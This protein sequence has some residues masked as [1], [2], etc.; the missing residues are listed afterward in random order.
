MREFAEIV[1][2]RR[3]GVHFD[4]YT[5]DAFWFAPGGAYRDWRR[6]TWPT[7][8][9][10]WLAE[11]RRHGI[12][13]GLWFST[14]TL[15][16]LDAAPAWKESLNSKQSAM[17]F[18]E[19]GFLPDFMATLQ[20]WY[21]RGIRLFKFDFADFSA[22]TPQAEKSQRPESIRSRNETAFRD[23]L[24]SFRRENPDVVLVAFNGFG[25][26]F[27][28]TAGPSPFH[29]R[30]DTRWLEV[31]DGLYSGDPRPSDVPQMNFWRSVDIYSDHM[32]RRFEQSGVP[33]ERIDSTAFMI[34]NT[35][36]NYYRKTAA[37][38][39]M[40]LLLVARGG[41]INTIYGNLEFID[42]ARAPWFAKVQSIYAPLQAVGRTESFGGLP[43]DAEPY[44]FASW[45]PG[46]IIYT[47]V[48]P[49]QR[50]QSIQLPIVAGIEAP[51]DQGRLLFCDAGFL[52]VLA[53]RAITLGPG[54]LATVGFG[55]FADPQF[56]LGIQK[57]VRIPTSIHPIS[58]HFEPQGA[59][60][61]AAVIS[62]P[63]R[64]DIR[65]V[66]QQRGPDKL[67]RRSWPGAPPDGTPLGKVLALHA[68]Q[69]GRNIP[70]EIGYDRVIWSGLSWA[71]GEV[72]RGSL[73]QGPLTIRCSSAEKDPMLLDAR[74]FVVEF[75]E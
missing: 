53:D 40:L 70:I 65:I 30:V 72:R 12:L 18:Y 35:G 13:P 49:S 43:G 66:L 63:Q 15:V 64:G 45:E 7:G 24:R 11:C 51:N 32:V 62:P 6:P 2:L 4:Y 56:D 58:A 42:D 50:I 69:N 8:P 48:N 26:D 37:W 17:S 20:H 5:M 34:G 67:V 16:K 36:T 27:E 22:A 60:A 29:N 3:C 44:G 57:D 14:N 39:G 54:Q 33:L 38:K 74:L 75:H 55:R 52:P 21:D 19:G 31:F 61:I 73:T 23:A 68:E 28:S 1:R 46:G 9:D 59:N 41:W 71:V 25:G 10:R 47:V